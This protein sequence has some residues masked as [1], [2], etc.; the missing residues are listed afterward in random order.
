LTADDCTPEETHIYPIYWAV[1]QN[2]TE[3]NGAPRELRLHPDDTHLGWSSFTTG[4][5]NTFFGRLEFNANPKTGNVLAPRYELVDVNLLY[6]PARSQRLVSDGNELKFL[7]DAIVVGELRGFSGTGDEILYIGPTWEANN[8][9]LSAIH[10]V[11]GAVR[12]L[13]EHPEYADPIAF[14]ADN[15]WIVTMDTRGSGRQMFM[16][17]M[18]HM[19]P[20]IDMVTVTIA[21]ST[22]NNGARRFFQP[23]LIDGYGDQDDYFGQQVNA[24]GDGS[25]GAVNDPNWNGRADPAFS[26]DGTKIVY[27]QAIVAG[28]ECGG[29]NPLPCP[30]PTTQGQREYRLMLARLTS[31]MPQ[32]VPPVFKVPDQLPWAT[33][34]PSGS[35]LPNES[36]KLV[37]GEYILRGKVSGTAGVNLSSST[38]DA[39]GAF[40][41]VAVNYTDYADVEGYVLNGW[42]K[43][44]ATVLWPNPWDTLVDWYSDIEQTGVVNATKQTSADGFHLQID[45]LLNIFDA[46]GTLVTNVDGVV[47]EQ[48]AN[49]T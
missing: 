37:A 32:A 28:R 26:H 43:V 27:W 10:V 3:A 41:T 6:D 1:I 39:S 20:L 14:S 34:F 16:S 23:I 44:T 8:I 12:R 2:G 48:P 5:Q 25:A 29:A 40:D 17:G 7:D 18:R 49:G 45:A 46:N 11:T 19:P 13:T 30:I 15:K 42:E 21:S 35:S 36:Q 22:R 33:P 9:D 31:R 24:E 47:Y 38:P 4:G